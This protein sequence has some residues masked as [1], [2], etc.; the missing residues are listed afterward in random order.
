M[1]YTAATAAT[2]ADLKGR[3]AGAVHQVALRTLHE[4]FEADRAGQIQT[5]ALTVSTEAT[6]PATGR[7]KRTELVAVGADRESFLS[8]DLHNVVPDATLKHLGASLSKNPYE[9][10]AIDGTRGVREV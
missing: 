6:D 9:L 8:F 7:E 5:I 3:Y 10:V 2:K 4:V 1:K